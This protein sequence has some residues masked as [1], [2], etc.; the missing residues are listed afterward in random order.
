MK[1]IKFLARCEL[2]ARRKCEQIIKD[3]CI[4][5]NNVCCLNPF[6]EI[7]TDTDS[8]KY[9]GKILSLS[10][11]KKKLYVLFFKPKRCITSVSDDK[12]RTTVMDYMKKIRGWANL[13]PIGRLDYDTEGLLLLTNDGDYAQ[14][15]QHPSNRILKIYQAKV[16]GIPDKDDLEKLK[17]NIKIDGK[18]VRCV[19]VKILK[20]LKSNSW[21]EIGIY[22]GQ[23]RIIRKL[24]DII[25]HSV[26]KL[27][28][29][30][31]GGFSLFD[32]KLAPGQYLILNE[33]E[34]DIVFNE[35]KKQ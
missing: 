4:T 1:L 11:F 23:N 9:N 14:T 33:R 20:K 17:K 5:V 30:A 26:I 21:I 19:S 3:G 22:S 13:Y 8:V 27:T 25:N 12:G 7:D 29:I 32:M 6:Q 16:E 35:K 31:I 34:K 28:R 10:K 24:C 18:T 2:D 15:I